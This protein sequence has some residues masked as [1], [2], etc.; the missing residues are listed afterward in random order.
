MAEPAEQPPT[1]PLAAAQSAAAALTDFTLT[2]EQRADAVAEIKE[3]LR[4]ADEAPR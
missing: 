4:Q 2:G 1:D 3:H